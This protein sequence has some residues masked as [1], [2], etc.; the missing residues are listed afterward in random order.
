MYLAAHSKKLIFL[1][2][3]RFLSLS[4]KNPFLRHRRIDAIYRIYVY[5]FTRKNIFISR[6]VRIYVYRY[7]DLIECILHGAA[8][9]ASDYRNTLRRM[10]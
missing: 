7:F 5:K 2:I 3:N 9:N 10:R 6:N 8:T 4:K 1:N